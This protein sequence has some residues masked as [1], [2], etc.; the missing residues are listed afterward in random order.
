MPSSQPLEFGSWILILPHTLATTALSW[1]CLELE[2]GDWCVQ[3]ACEALS[4]GGSPP[5]ASV[6]SMLPYWTTK[7][8]GSHRQ[9]G[10]ESVRRGLVG[11]TL[12]VH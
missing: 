8:L 4:S 12:Q 1:W 10:W 6:L 11:G 7:V 9:E 2:E 3:G 5:K